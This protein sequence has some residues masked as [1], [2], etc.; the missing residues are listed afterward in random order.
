V[1]PERDHVDARGEQ[2]V[3]ELRR[4]AEPVGRVLAVGD[5][6]IEVE[7]FTKARQPLLDGAQAWA[8]VYVCDEEEL[9]G[10]A[11]LAAGCTS[12]E[13]WFPASWV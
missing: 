2:L 10:I 7:L 13:A 9:Q 12:N 5:D 6:E 3:G 8:P 4:D 1:V 11:K